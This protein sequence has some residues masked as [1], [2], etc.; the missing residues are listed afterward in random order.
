MS[1][2]AVQ[3]MYCKGK[4]NPNWLWKSAARQCLLRNKVKHDFRNTSCSS[5][6]W[7]SL[8]TNLAPDLTVGHP[9]WTHQT[10]ASCFR[11]MQVKVLQSG[12]WDA[13]VILWGFDL[14]PC[15]VLWVVRHIEGGH[16]WG[17]LQKDQVSA[18]CNPRHPSCYE[19]RRERWGMR[20]HLHCPPG[21]WLIII[22]TS[23]GP[24][25]VD[26]KQSSPFILQVSCPT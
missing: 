4:N 26:S 19:L 14:V 8:F 22:A 5:F 24:G 7:N 16:H 18:D 2:D 11:R 20:S 1:W 21:C 23:T 13:V 6:A 3:F 17:G 15:A 12:F 25:E 9:T 10:C